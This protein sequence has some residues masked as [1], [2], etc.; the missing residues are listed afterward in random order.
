MKEKS[1]VFLG[2]L[3]LQ[4]AL[5][6]LLVEWGI[7]GYAL[8]ALSQSVSPLAAF[9]YVSGNRRE[10]IV[11]LT[12]GVPFLLVIWLRAFERI[13]VV[14]LLNAVLALAF[15]G[16]ILS[17]TLTFI[18]RSRSITIATISD[19]VNGYL[20]IGI[21]WVALFGLLEDLSSGSF[22]GVRTIYDL[23]YLSFITLTGVGTGLVSP[24]TPL[25]GFFVLLEA[26]I[27]TLYIAI[28]IALL[29][30]VYSVTVIQKRT[31]S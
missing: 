23:T 21:T 3:V 4:L 18:V 13:P 25:A 11:A 17:I 16:Y 1:L 19:A 5:Y 14:S 15:Y 7:R 29:V 28:I 10:T 8:F 2:A 9:Y 27:G 12:L 26:I 31:G 24:A 30:G 6:P 22:D 20:L